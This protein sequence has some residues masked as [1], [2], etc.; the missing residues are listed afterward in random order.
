MADALS[1]EQIDAMLNAA[2]SGGT[3]ETVAEVE[4]EIKEYDF[5]S[6]KKFTRERLKILDNIFDGYGR[7]LSSYLTGLLR[8]YCQVSLVS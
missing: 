4:D 8:L 2:M 1:Q 6:P 5:R 3:I 7:V